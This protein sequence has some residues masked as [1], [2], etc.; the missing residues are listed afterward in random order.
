MIIIRDTRNNRIA[1][2][3]NLFTHFTL[4]MPITYRITYLNYAIAI[5]ALAGRIAGVPRKLSSD[6]NS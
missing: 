1:L 5:F 3:T 2:N 4:L 6:Y